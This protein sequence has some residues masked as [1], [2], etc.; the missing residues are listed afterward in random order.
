MVGGAGP[1]SPGGRGTSRPP[2]LIAL[3]D[4]SDVL[5]QAWLM[6]DVAGAVVVAMAVFLESASII[7][8]HE[9]ISHILRR[10]PMHLI[11]LRPLRSCV[12]SALRAVK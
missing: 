6:V 11:L 8:Q 9:F 10:P 1:G 2:V 12:A 3:L 5:V 4:K 7:F